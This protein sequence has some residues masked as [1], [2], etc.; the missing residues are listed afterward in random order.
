MSNSMAI[1]KIGNARGTSAI[2]DP[3][4]SI[5]S[6]RLPTADRHRSDARDE[7]DNQDRNHQNKRIAQSRQHDL[8]H[9]APEIE[10][11]AKIALHKFGDVRKILRPQRLIQSPGRAQLLLRFRRQFA[12]TQQ[13]GSW[14]AGDQPEH[15]EHDGQKQEQGDHGLDEP[16]GD[17]SPENHLSSGLPAGCGRLQDTLRACQADP[18]LVFVQ[19]FNLGSLKFAVSVPRETRLL[20]DRSP[21]IDARLRRDRLRIA[22]LLQDRRD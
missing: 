5:G 17:K 13:D 8:H 7:G 21:L 2:N 19:Q 1:Q 4:F 20:E 9:R 3:I 14:V 11:Q 12:G 15:H 10:R 18:H 22:P 16:A 6:P